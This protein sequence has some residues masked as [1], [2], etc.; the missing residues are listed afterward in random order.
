MKLI[1]ALFAISCITLLGKE[2]EGKLIVNM[3]GFAHDRGVVRVHLHNNPEYFPTKSR[4]AFM[5][6]TTFVRG[7]NAKVVFESVP[8]GD[9]ALSVHHDE[10]GNR[11]MNTNFLG[12]PNEDYGVSNNVKSTFGPPDFEEAK[13]AINKKITEINIEIQ[14]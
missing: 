12:I 9:Y 13:F 6:D 4:K 11:R 8:Y 2:P 5:R 14:K 3:A 7:T 10:D 1:L